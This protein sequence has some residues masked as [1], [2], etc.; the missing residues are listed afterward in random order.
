MNALEVLLGE[1][2]VGLL[3]RFDDE[4]YV[5]SFE[6]G[7]LKMPG[8]RCSGSSSRTAGPGTWRRRGCRAGLPIF[9]LKARFEGP[10]PARP[11][12]TRPTGSTS[13]QPWDTT[14]RAV[15]LRAAGS[16][17]SQRPV[18]PPAILPAD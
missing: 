10:S 14:S 3:E 7:W 15:M 1:V 16:R 12:S 17:T 11:A 8:R 6:P 13:S 2:K 18:A 5:F 4:E 9:S